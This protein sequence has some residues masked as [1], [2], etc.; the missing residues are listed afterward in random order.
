MQMPNCS[1]R[2]VGTTVRLATAVTILGAASL[3][4][5]PV[6][7]AVSVEDARMS[8]ETAL[9]IL[10]GDA[11][12]SLVRPGAL[13]AEALSVPQ[14]SEMLTVVVRP[15]DT[16]DGLLRRH[17]AN[18]VFNIKFQRQALMRL[19]PS[20]FQNGQPQRL[21]VGTTLWIPNDTVMMALLPGARKEVSVV[22]TS[23][24]PQQ[25]TAEQEP[26]GTAHQAV[27]IPSPYRGWVRFP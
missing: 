20:V 19:N 9:K 16:V 22:Q 27:H 26:L 18:S 8:P 1:S 23:A 12:Q 5:Q 4:A 25:L 10:L 11:A 14:R 2:F 13:V 7:Q 6:G 15:G 24:A 21:T 3:S 17:L